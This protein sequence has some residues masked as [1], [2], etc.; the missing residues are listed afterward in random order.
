MHSII[1]LYF[2]CLLLFSLSITLLLSVSTT[3]VIIGSPKDLYMLFS[4]TLHTVAELAKKLPIPKDLGQDGHKF[5]PPE[6]QNCISLKH[7][8]T[9]LSRLA[10]FDEVLRLEKRFSTGLHF[11]IKGWS[12]SFSVDAGMTTEDSLDE[13]GCHCD[14][15]VEDLSAPLKAVIRAVRW[16]LALQIHFL[17]LPS[18]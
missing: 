15:T 13:R 17:F 2:L 3:L 9:L 10:A 11:L 4:L 12:V 7:S 16:D 6:S 8:W 5:S 18:S 14:V 1:G